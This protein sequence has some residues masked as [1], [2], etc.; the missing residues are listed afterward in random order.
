MWTKVK[1]GNVGRRDRGSGSAWAKTQLRF[2]FLFH[3]LIS[4]HHRQYAPH[5][6]ESFWIYFRNFGGIE[7]NAHY[8][9]PDISSSVEY[10]RHLTNRTHYTTWLLTSR[11]SLNCFACFFISNFFLHLLKHVPASWV[12]V[13]LPFCVDFEQEFALSQKSRTAIS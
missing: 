8:S 3:N 13:H 2:H 12:L 10:E 5:H 4:S 1:D 6:S 9:T 7:K 11:Q